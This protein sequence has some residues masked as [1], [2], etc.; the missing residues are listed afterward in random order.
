MSEPLPA[1]ATEAPRLVAHDS[2]WAAR[3]REYAAEVAD[4]FGDRLATGVEHV[5]STAVPGLRAKPIIDL[6]AVAH[7]PAAAVGEA[8]DAAATAGWMLVPRELDRRPWRWFLVRVD[9]AAR[10][11]LAHLHLTAPGQ[12]RWAEQLAFRDCLRADPGLRAEYAAVKDRAI[13]DH[14][15]DREA[16]GDT[17]AAFVR[18]VLAR[19]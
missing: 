5:G 6:Q 8:R 7:D 15:A 11:R 10:T 17:K 14:P 19:L 16:Y 12:D 18:R 3:A 1:W 4:L 2:A 13:A 9:D